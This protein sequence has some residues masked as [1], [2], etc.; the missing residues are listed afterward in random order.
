MGCPKVFPARVTAGSIARRLGGARTGGGALFWFLAD[1]E[2]RRRT[3]GRRGLDDALRA[4]VAE[5]GTLGQLWSVER[6]IATADRAVGAPVLR[7]LYRKMA[8]S[9]AP[10]DLDALWRSL[11]VRRDEGHIS[12]DEAAPLAW[13]R[14]AIT[15]TQSAARAPPPGARPPKSLMEAPPT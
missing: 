1:V 6:V 10:V 2:I 7:D 4:I 5:G 14:R 8:T 9:P 3:S 11:G 13:V 15:V 12:F